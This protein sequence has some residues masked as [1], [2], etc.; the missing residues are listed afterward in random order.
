MID[1]LTKGHERSIKAKKNILALF[2]L[3]GMMITLS[4]VRLPL[5]LNYLN[6]T[7]FGIWLTIESITRWFAFFDIGLSNGLKNKLV[8]AFSKKD[9]SL[10]R[11][12]ISTTYA[13]LF[14]I[15]STFYIVFLIITPFLNWAQIFNTTSA[16]EG[17]LSKLVHIVFTFFAIRFTIELINTILVADHKPAFQSCLTALGD[18]IYTVTI[19]ILLQTTS[20]SLFSVGIVSG[21]S[22]IIVILLASI[23]LYSKKYKRLKPSIKFVDFKYF[24]DLGSLS[25]QF[26]FIQVYCVIIFSTDNMIITQLFTPDKVVPYNI[27]FK[28]MSLISIGFSIIM[29]PLWA[30]YTDAYIRDDIEWI[31]KITQK[32]LLIWG[33]ILVGIIGLIVISKP[34]Y[35]YWIGDEVTIPLSLSIGMGVFVLISTWNNIFVYFINAV[36]KIRLQLYFSTFA[37][38]INIPASIFFSKNLQLGISGVILGTCLSLLIGAIFL[39]IQYSKIINKRAKNIWAK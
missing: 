18:L 36:G 13:T 33:I 8:E 21:I 28:Y 38:L 20:G 17:M 32:L 22:P 27:A 7:N 14:I 31:K 4:L 29:T 30:A 35:H 39:P 16:M 10:A 25:I 2:I 3:R 34:F 37:A 26:F 23:I 6:S 19:Y 5:M 9:S 24:R 1:F 15:A 11:T 12:Y